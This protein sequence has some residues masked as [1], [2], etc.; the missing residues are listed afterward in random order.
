MDNGGTG[1]RGTEPD[2]VGRD[3][4]VRTHT[5]TICCL[6]VE[7]SGLDQWDTQVQCAEVRDRKEFESEE[8]SETRKTKMQ[9]TTGTDRKCAIFAEQDTE[10]NSCILLSVLGMTDCAQEK[11][12]LL[13]SSVIPSEKKRQK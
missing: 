2:D 6:I 12:W 4:T 11:K 7:L 3:K 10:A 8:G 9:K 1:V 13:Q 5:K